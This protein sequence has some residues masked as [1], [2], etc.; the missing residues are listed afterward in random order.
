MSNY[1]VGETADL[2]DP[3][4]GAW[5]GVLDRNGKEQEVATSAAVAAAMGFSFDAQGNLIANVV[6]RTGMLSDLLGYAGGAGE[7]ASAT[8]VPAIVQYS[9]TVGGAKS[10]FPQGTINTSAPVTAT[11]TVTVPYGQAVY[12][13]RIN[14]ASLVTLTINMATGPAIDGDRTF[15]YV[16]NSDAGVVTGNSGTGMAVCPAGFFRDGFLYE[17]MMLGGVWM[18]IDGGRSVAQ[19]LAGGFSAAGGQAAGNT[20]A[21]GGN[22]FAQY[23]GS[24]ALAHSFVGD[25]GANDAQA[26]D[27]VIQGGSK[28]LRIYN[29]LILTT[30]ATTANQELT[31]T[32]GA[33]NSSTRFSFPTLSVAS[34]A[35]VRVTLQGR[36]GASGN[37]VWSNTYDM[38]LSVSGLGAATLIGAVVAGTAITGGAGIAPTAASVGIVSNKLQVLVTPSATTTTYWCA[39]IEVIQQIT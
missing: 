11:G 30:S 5:V 8:D 7:L 35:R 32:G 34:L 9:G 16:T 31:L 29:D 13:L 21:I 4:T 1:R 20:V 22:T 33:A 28:T 25:V 10:F 26:N 27:V 2:F 3:T 19:I 38:V 12:V 15:I 14:S 37:N 18:P 23:D 24:V 6:P 17:F 39:S 36:A